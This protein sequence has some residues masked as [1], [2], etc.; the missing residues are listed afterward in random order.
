V[1]RFTDHLDLQM[2]EDGQGR[3]MLKDGRVQ[4]RVSSP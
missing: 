3:P 4:W 2:L 1:S